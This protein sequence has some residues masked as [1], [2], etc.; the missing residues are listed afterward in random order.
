MLSGFCAPLSIAIT[1]K[2]ISSASRA[3]STGSTTAANYYNIL[4]GQQYR[5][6]PNWQARSLSKLATFITA[7]LATPISAWHWLFRS[8][9]ISYH[10]RIRNFRRQSIRHG[11]LRLPIER[12]QQKYQFRYDVF[13]SSG[14]HAIRFGVNLIHEPVLRGALAST[15]TS[16]PVHPGSI[17]LSQPSRA[18][19]C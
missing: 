1:R 14:R 16:R 9:Q 4:L 18:I 5:F 6:S 2:T 17:L 10:L 12:D 13:R 19:Y 11:S 7:R 3:S 15:R 8:A